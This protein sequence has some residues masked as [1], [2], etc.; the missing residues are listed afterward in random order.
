MTQTL[1]PTG[2]SFRPLADDELRGANDLFRAS[3]HDQPASDENWA[4]M[5][6]AYVADRTFGAFDGDRQV[7]TATSFPSSLTVPGGNILPMS[8]VTFVG[9]R[10]DHRRRGALTGLMNAQLLD[11]AARGEVFAGLH[12]SEPVI[13]GRFGYGVATVGRTL[14]VLTRRAAL[15]PEV[16]T[17]GRVRLLD[18]DEIVPALQAAYPRVQPTRHGLMGRSPQWWALG[19]ERRLATDYL[20]VAAHFDVEGAIDGWVSYRPEEDSSD[21]PRAGSGLRVLDFQS[22][23]Q[24]VANDLWRYLLGVDL[25]DDVVAYVRPTD[26]PLE[27][28]LVNA[29]AIRSDLD[30]ELWLRIVDVPAALA[31]RAYNAAA[32]VVVEVVDPLLPNNS[33]RYRVGPDGVARTTDTPALTVD[34][35]ALA[36]LYLGTW[37]ATTLADIGRLA[38]AD[39]TALADA[40]RLFATDRPAWSGTL[41]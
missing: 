23:D 21:D 41:F 4:V 16:P 9:V 35:E 19:Y 25:V 15:R 36:M 1:L 26:D 29:H 18:N 32:P 3:L 12:A 37:R 8:G 31:G 2:L 40:D 34:P 10:T 28:M 7:G 38:V 6:R 17:A 11:I 30:D 14:K 33:G 27:A 24:G 20:L 13:Y 5:V 39:R 22:V